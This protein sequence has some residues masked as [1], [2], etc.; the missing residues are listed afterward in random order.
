MAGHQ[1]VIKM[2]LG[3]LGLKQTDPEMLGPEIFLSLEQRGLPA[4]HL[5]LPLP[6][7]RQPLVGLVGWP[8]PYDAYC[9]LKALLY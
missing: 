2:S 3:C 5:N 1:D 4:R 8:A 6:L 7:P 9:T